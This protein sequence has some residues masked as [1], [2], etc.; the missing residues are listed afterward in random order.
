MATREPP[1]IGDGISLETGGIG[2]GPCRMVDMD[3]WEHL[4]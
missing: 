3:F 1:T 2:P 4:F